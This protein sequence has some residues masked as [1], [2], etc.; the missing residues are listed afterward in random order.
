MSTALS[1]SLLGCGDEI[2]SF[3]EGWLVVSFCVCV[4]EMYLRVMM[5]V[6]SS[7]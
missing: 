2:S 4:A 1:I 7:T 6:G 5:F 3:S